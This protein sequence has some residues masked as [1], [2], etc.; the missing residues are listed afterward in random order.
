LQAS[1][2]EIA[3]ELGPETEAAW[4]G[5]RLEV[6]NDGASPPAFGSRG[7]DREQEEPL[8]HLLAHAE[9]REVGKFEMGQTSLLPQNGPAPETREQYVRDL[10]DAIRFGDWRELVISRRPVPLPVTMAAHRRGLVDE[11]VA[12]ILKACAESPAVARSWVE[13]AVKRIEAALNEVDTQAQAV[14]VYELERLDPG[15]VEVEE[16]TRW[17]AL[18]ARL[19]KQ[20]EKWLQAAEEP[21]EFVWQRAALA[22]DLWSECRGWGPAR[23]VLEQ[24]FESVIAEARAM[25]HADAVAAL[26]FL[27]EEL[28]R[29][30]WD[31]LASAGDAPITVDD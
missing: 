21:L 19:G 9:E 29:P 24:R 20:V 12:S 15:E 28:Q 2:A 17:A 26:E 16:R 3:R 8:R 22:G 30:P 31:R 6:P 23:G 13:A 27:F 11:Q 7:A 14:M 5:F 1:L 4:R 18:A 10:A 25:Y